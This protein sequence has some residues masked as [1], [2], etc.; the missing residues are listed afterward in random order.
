MQPV[1]RNRTATLPDAQRVTPAADVPAWRDYLT[2][3]KP[4]ISFLVTISAL[5][6]F[7]LGSP[8]GVDG[9]RLVFTLL[10]TLLTSCGVSVLNHLFEA[11]LD[12]SMRRTMNRPLPAGRLS[13]QAARTFG[14]VLAGA[15]I[16]ILCPLVNPLTAVL[17]IATGVLYLYVYTPLK[18]TTKYNTL[19]G[20]IPGALPALGGWTAATN[21]LGAGGWAIFGILLAWQMP[22]FLSLAWMYRKDYDRGGYRMLP[23]VEPD[24]HSTVRQTLGFTVLLLAISLTPAWLGLLSGVYAVGA[25]LL[26]LAFLKPAVDFYRT[27]S[28]QDA[29]RVLKASIWY[30]PALVLLIVVDRL[31]F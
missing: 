19:V 15:G 23:V 9:W 11:D 27:R 20:T 6:G 10:G 14:F 24:G 30:I 1:P 21:S 2:L 8:D 4:E 18:R 17:A 28:V 3:T 22:H 13:P 12:A 25:L 26:G 7:L 29:R 5:A 16:G 31:L